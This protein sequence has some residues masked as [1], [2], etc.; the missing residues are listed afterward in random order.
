M[1][2]SC[3]S[4]ELKA[5]QDGDIS[6]ASEET[7]KDCCCGQKN[8]VATRKWKSAQMGSE[9]GEHAKASEEQ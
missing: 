1:A 2:A 6:E 4:Q 7:E 5:E 9:N 3:R 8:S